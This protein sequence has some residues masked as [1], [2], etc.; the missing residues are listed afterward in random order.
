MIELRL[1][2]DLDRLAD[3]IRGFEAQI[4]FAVS[5]AVN[6]LGDDVAAAERREILDVFDRP[7]PFIQR[8][9]RQRKSTKRDLRAQVYIEFNAG[10]T[11]PEQVLQAEIEG[12][13]RALKPFERRLRSAGILPSGFFAV[14]GDGAKRD[15][16][17][18]MQGGQITQI[19][20]YFRAFR[21]RGFDANI[22]DRNKLKRGTRKNPI[23]I[24]Y[25]VGRPGD[26]RAPLGVWQRAHS[27]LG[28]ITSV[29]PILI[30][31]DAA[32]YEPIYDFEFVAN[33]VL[34][35]RTGPVLDREIAHAIATARIR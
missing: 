24:S 10:S 15:A 18:N 1:S 9:V 11:P 16:F 27:K 35:R 20:A 30:F 14:P 8:S 3:R 29:T 31:V 2:S 34:R 22:A 26:G 23:G 13:E 19:L 12:G 33:S 7:T 17:G 4:P 25:F 21:D 6:A 32:R 28:K 5:R